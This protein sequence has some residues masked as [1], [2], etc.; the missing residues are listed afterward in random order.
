MRPAPVPPDEKERLS[1]L[2]RYDLLDTL[3]EQ[4][5]DDLTELAAYV[6]RVP[7]AL[8]SLVDSDRV[9]FKSRLGL[10]EAEVD[11]TYA[12]CAHTV[13]NGDLL[14][15]PNTTLNRQFA[16]NPMVTG[17][18]AVRFYA[19]TPLVSHD[20]YPLGTLCVIDSRPRKLNR[21]QTEMLR[22]I[23]RQVMSQ[24]E[25]RLHINDHQRI[26]RLKSEFV[27]VVSHELRTPLTSI[28]GSLGLI[29]GGVLGEVPS[30]MCRLVEVARSNTD[31]LIRLIND[32][33]DLEKIEAGKL[34]LHPRPLDPEH[35]VAV[36][37]AEIQGMADQSQVRLTWQAEP[38]WSAGRPRMLGDFD[39]LLQ[40]LINLFSNAIKASPSGGTVDAR[41]EAGDGGRVRLSVHDHGP[42]IPAH[43]LSRIFGKFQQIDTSDS[44]SRG[45]TGLGLSICKAIV[46]QHGGVIGVETEEGKG[47]TFWF[48]IPAAGLAE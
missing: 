9:W 27:S 5:Y 18:L 1:A 45:G 48:E 39:R 11:R 34:A 29:E 10:C 16:D 13:F 21:K 6:C 20:G 17:G 15:I 12:F 4:V 7:I 35:L 44:R 37:A 47:S 8:V 3:P 38:S 46:E 31:R 42:G 23:G 41:I 2:R 33:L 24:I 28:R 36:A 19:G 43:E 30:P 14:V 40:V 32:I 26:E 22:A 25:L